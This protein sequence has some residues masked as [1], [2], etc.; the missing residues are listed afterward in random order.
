MSTLIQP[1]YV[2]ASNRTTMIKL[3]LITLLCVAV[4][5]NLPIDKFNQPGG[6]IDE[7][8]NIMGQSSP[9]VRRAAQGPQN[10]SPPN[11]PPPMRPPPNGQQSKPQ[12]NGFS[13][14]LKGS[15]LG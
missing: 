2:C 3:F 6:K 12:Q 5:A 1:V 7:L 9:L 14:S 10:G 4:L 11:E 15:S 8:I 13:K